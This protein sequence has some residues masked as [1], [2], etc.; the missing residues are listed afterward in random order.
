MDYLAAINSRLAFSIPVIYLFAYNI[1]Y[2]IDDTAVF[3]CKVTAFFAEITHYFH[4]RSPFF[5]ANSISGRTHC[6]TTDYF[7]KNRLNL[8]LLQCS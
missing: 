4:F 1:I 7:I 8:P 6:V 2:S 3:L 5:N